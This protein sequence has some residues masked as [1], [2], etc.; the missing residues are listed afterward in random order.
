MFSFYLS[1][2]YNQVFFF[3]FFFKAFDSGRACN[4]LKFKK[5]KPDWMKITCS[6]RYSIE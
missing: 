2:L 6:Q 3:V 1:V 5:K 4:I